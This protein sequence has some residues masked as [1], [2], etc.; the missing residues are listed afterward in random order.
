M[1]L[2]SWN[3]KWDV[4]LH[5]TLA[6]VIVLAVTGASAEDP[7]AGFDRRHTIRALGGPNALAPGGVQTKA[8]LQ[9]HFVDQADDIRAVLASHG[10]GDEV[11]DALLLAVKTD[12]GITERSLV[13]GEQ[14]AW[15]AYRRRGEAVT[16]ADV[17]LDL[18]ESAPAFEIAVPVVVSSESAPAD[19]SLDVSE[20]QTGATPFRVSAASD[21][22]VVMEGPDGSQHVLTMEDGS[23]SGPQSTVRDG[24]YTFTASNT[25]ETIQ[26]VQIYRF[27][28]PRECMN[29][30][31]VEAE[32]VERPGEPAT[33]TQTVSRT[34]QMPEEPQKPQ[35]QELWCEMDLSTTSA[36][37][38]ELVT[39]EVTGHWSRLDVELSHDRAALARAALTARSGSFE[40][41]RRGTYTV[42]GRAWD[43]TGRS[44][45][46]PASVEVVGSNWVVRPFGAAQLVNG[47]SALADLTTGAVQTGLRAS[48]ESCP[49]ALDSAYGY[50]DGYGFGVSLERRLS[51]RFGLELRGVYSRLDDDL[52]LGAN[53]LHVAE[54]D[55]RTLWDVSIGLNVHLNPY[56]SV[57]WYV[58]PFVGYGDVEGD[59][60]LA[61]GSSLEHD[62]EGDVSW[63]AQAGVDWPLGSSPWS[64]HLAARYTRLAVDVV[65]RF[66]SSAGERSEQPLSVDLD[67][68]TVELGVAYR[69]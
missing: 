18:R 11:A 54:S 48:L 55:Q 8:D 45:T 1:D 61:V 68:I 19:C 44:V 13:N 24:V 41:R 26:R 25:A 63:G 29:L 34:C 43:D 7:C 49:C 38:G 15:M 27:L 58:G 31:L 23:W 14:L 59:E 20:C 4:A 65:Q 64:A 16:I 28:V 17:C 47:D 6:V 10:L 22:K 36:R 3:R 69:F 62:V 39:Y 51:D 40:V 66:T 53:G 37:R 2:R 5:V 33:C 35:Q 42:T 21:A 60:S 50:D 30:A 46:C 9:R 57:D 12:E 67:P 52:W 56:G 32:P